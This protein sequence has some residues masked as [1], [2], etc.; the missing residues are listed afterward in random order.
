LR[1]TLLKLGQQ[2]HVLLAAAHH[3]IYD[4][5]S[6]GIMAR[7]LTAL[8]AAYG[9]GRPSPLP[10]L[11]IQYADFAA[12]QRQM[13]QGERLERLRA[14]WSSNWATCRPGIAH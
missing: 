5:W 11:P 13:L 14:Y 6:L 8:Y 12:W 7:E 9:A 3:M 10:E 2:E 4:G 1:I